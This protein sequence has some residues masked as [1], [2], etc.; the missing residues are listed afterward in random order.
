MAITAIARVKAAAF[1]LKSGMNESSRRCRKK[2]PGC[3]EYYDKDGKSLPGKKGISLGK[4]QWDV[5]YS[6]RDAIEKAC[7]A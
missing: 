5:V 6:N 2:A 3:W 1:R 7:A 4:E